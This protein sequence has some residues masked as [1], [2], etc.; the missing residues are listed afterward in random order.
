MVYPRLV[1]GSILVSD[2]LFLKRDLLYKLYSINSNSLTPFTIVAQLVECVVYQ[3]KVVSSILVSCIFF[4]KRDSLYQ[5]YRMNL[6]PL[7]QLCMV[8]QLV[9]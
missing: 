5:L 1:V 4:F 7:T 8:A 2:S 6:A 3:C 9:K